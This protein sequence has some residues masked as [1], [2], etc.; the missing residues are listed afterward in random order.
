MELLNS[1]YRSKEVHSYEDNFGGNVFDNYFYNYLLFRDG[2]VFIFFSTPMVSSLVLERLIR[3]NDYFFSER[4][5]MN[6]LPEDNL[7][8]KMRLLTNRIIIV[9]DGNELI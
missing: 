5:L 1:L 3:K 9:Y 8:D 2:Q 7:I 4:I 6:E